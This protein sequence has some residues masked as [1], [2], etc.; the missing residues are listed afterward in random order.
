LDEFC[1]REQIKLD[2]FREKGEITWGWKE[3]EERIEVLPRLL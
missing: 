1:E 2:V 3:R